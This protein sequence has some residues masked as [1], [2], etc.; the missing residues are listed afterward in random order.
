MLLQQ[1]CSSKQSP[2]MPRSSSDEQSSTWAQQAISSPPTHWQQTSAQPPSPLSSAYRMERECNQCT[3]ALLISPSFQ[4][5]PEMPTS[6]WPCIALPPVHCY[7]VQCQLCHHLHQDWML[8]CVSWL[9]YRLWPQMHAHWPLDDPTP[10]HSTPLQ[11]TPL[12]TSHKFPSHTCNGCQ[13]QGHVV[14]HQ[15]CPL[16]PSTPVLPPTSTLI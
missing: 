12:R 6:P 9:H 5:L 3:L 4:P 8:H 1:R 13:C 16:H 7:N 2:P 10:L 15:V 11:S 14:C